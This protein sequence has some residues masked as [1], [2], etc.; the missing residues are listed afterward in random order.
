[1]AGAKNQDDDVDSQVQILSPHIEQKWKE[2]NIKDYQWEDIYRESLSTL[3][4]R[5][6]N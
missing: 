2:R 1:M 6:Y 4:K 5:L 3:R